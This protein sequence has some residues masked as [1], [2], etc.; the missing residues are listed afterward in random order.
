MRKNLAYGLTRVQRKQ[1]DGLLERDTLPKGEKQP[2]LTRPLHYC[3]FVLL[4]DLCDS[5]GNF[6]ALFD[7]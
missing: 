1:G 7:I 3:A 4:Y 5:W 2:G 6:I